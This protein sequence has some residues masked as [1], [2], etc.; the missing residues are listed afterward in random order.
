MHSLG[1]APLLTGITSTSSEYNTAT[2]CPTAYHLP[3]CGPVPRQRPSGMKRR[4]SSEEVL[5]HTQNC[6]LSIS[7]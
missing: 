6:V 4:K 2:G 3:R 5:L 7:S 1:K